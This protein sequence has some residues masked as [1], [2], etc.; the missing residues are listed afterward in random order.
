MKYRVFL[1]VSISMLFLA[2]CGGSSDS[3]RA[4]PAP[5]ATQPDGDPVTDVITAQFDAGAG[6]IPFPNNLLLQGTTDLTL[7]IP[8]EDPSDF[9]NPQVALNALDGFSTIAPWTATFSEE[10][11]PDSVIPGSSVRVYEV[12]LQ[13]GG[14]A[15]TGVNRELTPGQDFVAAVAG[16]DPS[17]QTLAILPLRPLQEMTAYMAVLT[18]G[19]TD[20]QGN[21]ATPSQQYFLA[22]RTDPLIDGEGN[23]TEPL[24]DDVSAQQLEGLRQVI[25]THEAAAASEGVD[26]DSIVLSWTMTTQAIQPV[27]GQLSSIAEPADYNLAPTGLNTGDLIPGSPGIA[28]VFIGTITLPYYLGVPSADNP[29]A[30][31]TEFWQAEPGAYIPPFDAFGLDPDSTNVTVANPFPVVRDDQTV[32]VLLSVPNEGSGQVRP[33]SG[34]PAVIFQHGITGNRSQMLALADTMAS[35]GFATIA[36]DLPLHGITDTDPMDP[37]QPLAPLY[38][39]NTPFDPIAN[40]RTFDLDLDQDG[41]P[42]PSGS[43]FI[44][45]QSLLTARDNLRQGQADLITLAR[46]IPTMDF[47]GDGIADFDGSDINFA[48]L[49][50][51]AMTGIPFM[52][53]EPTVSNGVLS[54]PGG[55]IV[56]F[57]VASESFGPVIIAGLQEAGV[58]PGSAEFN[59]FLLAAQTVIDSADPINWGSTAVQA[60][61]FLLHQ[62]AGDS[63]IPN[64]VPGQ[65]LSGTEPLISVMDLDSITETVQDPMGIRGAVRFIQGGHGSLLDPSIDPAVTQEMQSQA[66]SM[67]ASGGTTVVV[68][69]DSVIATD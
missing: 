33:G 63:V 65:P 53:V 4:V 35:I 11:D 29:T 58:E 45:L 15:V 14:I 17:G 26:R 39:G 25:N 21:P 68:T 34:W 62:V 43:Y 5:P 10:I 60:N 44:N 54:A 30:P 67:I 51:G 19:I 64:A 69:N 59:Q 6:V 13:Q 38:V 9:G 3:D 7:N 56:N 41:Q 55:G 36:I 61:S 12:Q 2:A 24:L 40:E 49:S 16:S 37:D 1:V 18:D 32:P 23:S 66:G 31:L 57:L 47:T 8:V 22:K 42:D 28:D 20:L 52:T 48:G 46:T 27:L 50:L